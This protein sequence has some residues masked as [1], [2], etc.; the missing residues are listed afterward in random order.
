MLKKVII[1]AGSGGVG[2]F[3][4][5][6]QT[7]SVPI[8]LGGAGLGAGIGYMIDKFLF[9]DTSSSTDASST[10]P[11]KNTQSASTSTTTSSSAASPSKE[12]LSIDG[13]ALTSVDWMNYTRFEK[14]AVAGA[15]GKS[16]EEVEEILTNQ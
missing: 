9:K 16:V 5:R 14:S 7:E 6:S 12:V 4:A 13:K 1:M 2:F 11:P 8:Q 10:S 3:V 15:L